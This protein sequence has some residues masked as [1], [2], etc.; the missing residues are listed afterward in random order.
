MTTCTQTGVYIYS[1]GDL[2]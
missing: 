2:P 1:L